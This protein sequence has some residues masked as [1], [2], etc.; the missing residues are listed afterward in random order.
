MRVGLSLVVVALG[1]LATLP[2]VASGADASERATCHGLPVTT[3]QTSGTIIGTPKRDVIR[4]TG[5]GVVRSGG[6][7]DVICG[8]RGPDVIRTGAGDDVVLGGAGADRIHAGRGRD[9]VFGE[10]GDDRI[11]GGPGRDAIV[12]GAGRETIARQTGDLILP[13]T[14]AVSAVISAPAAAQIAEAGQQ[15][16]L[17]LTTELPIPISSAAFPAPQV[18]FALGGY[19]V[20]TANAPVTVGT[21]PYQVD[22]AV[23]ALG[24]A[25]N[26][27]GPGVLMPDADAP[28]TPGAVT[29]ANQS[30]GPIAAGLAQSIT[31]FGLETTLSQIAFATEGVTP[32]FSTAVIAPEPIVALYTI[33]GGMMGTVVPALPASTGIDRLSP[34]SPTAAFAWSTPE[35][36]FVVD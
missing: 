31:P 1:A 12:G 24:S 4:L 33:G 18:G 32:G 2:A 23:T 25:W 8:S 19:G 29:V 6:G 10:A 26:S 34:A 30:P 27:V 35:Q 17:S 28:G 36:R 7:D 5:P 20:F 11:D 3:T 15:I 16:G 21:S 22:I 14:F 9:H 13:G